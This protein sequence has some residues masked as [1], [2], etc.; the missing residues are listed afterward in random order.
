MYEAIL[1]PPCGLFG[2]FG[3]LRR[4]LDDALASP[5]LRRLA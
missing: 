1:N 5:Q 4:E 2:Q 3:R